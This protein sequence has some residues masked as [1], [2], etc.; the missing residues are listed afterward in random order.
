MIRLNKLGSDLKHVDLLAKVEYFNPGGSIKDRV[1]L[2]MIEQAEKEGLLKPGGTIIEATAGNTGAG[3][4]LVAAQKGYRCI[5][6]MPD[7]MSQDKVNLLKAYGAE[8]VITAT[9][10]PPDSPESYNGVAEKLAGEIPNAF[11]PGQFT[12]AHNPAMHEATTGPEIW[13]QTQGKVDVVVAGMGTGGTISG[14]GRYLKSRKPSVKMIGADP[15]G[16]ILSGDSPKAFKVEG[17][18]EDFIPATLDR[19]VIEDFIRVSDQESFTAARRL[20][21]EEGLLVGGSSGTAMAAALKYCQRY[22]G[23]DTLTVVVM[24]PDT[25]RNYLTKVFSDEWMAQQGFL[26]GYMPQPVVSDLLAAAGQQE[27]VSTIQ[28]DAPASALR[29]YM[30]KNQGASVVVVMD[31]DAI[32]GRVSELTLIA[33]WR[34]GKLDETQAVGSLMGQ[35]L[36]CVSMSTTVE[37]AARRFLTGYEGLVVVDDNHRP[38]AMLTRHALLQFYARQPAATS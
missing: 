14:V 20:A 2:N 24:L 38:T 30:E 33:Q 12:N 15:E 18:G 26:T 9:S 29:P 3:L 17:I 10:V 32:V 34:K 1:A 25:G 16:S 28:A 37:E 7:K 35:P 4:A 22:D 21:R 11:R 19:Q 31:G 6:V 13:E 36:P 8:V 23:P 5:F 27:P